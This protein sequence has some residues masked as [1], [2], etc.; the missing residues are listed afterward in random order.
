MNELSIRLQIK[1]ICIASVSYV[2]VRFCFIA[3]D[4]VGKKLP[5][6]HSRRVVSKMVHVAGSGTNERGT[7]FAS[8]KKHLY[9]QCV[10]FR[11]M[12]LVYVQ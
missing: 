6:A 12:L 11:V 10:L 2:N 8:N 1:S 4:K 9:R 5:Y 7:R 3:N